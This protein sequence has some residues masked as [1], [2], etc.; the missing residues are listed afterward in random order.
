MSQMRSQNVTSSLAVIV[1]SQKI[2]ARTLHLIYI[3]VVSE[4]Q[5]LA[6]PYNPEDRDLARLRVHAGDNVAGRWGINDDNHPCRPWK[7]YIHVQNHCHRSQHLAAMGDAVLRR[8][9]D[10][11]TLL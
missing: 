1:V 4:T 3:P 10:C 2:E 6:A 5:R 8:G 7:Y 11:G 9:R